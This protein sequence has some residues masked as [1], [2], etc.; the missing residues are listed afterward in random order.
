MMQLEESDWVLYYYY[1]APLIF[2][3]ATLGAVICATTHSSHHDQ[4]T[5][6]NTV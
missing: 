2:K 5:M 3:P 4:A 1:M 6:V